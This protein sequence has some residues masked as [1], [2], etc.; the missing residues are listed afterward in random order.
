MPELGLGTWQNRGSQCIESVEKA[1]EIGYRHVDTAQIYGN[2]SEVG[3]GIKN[4]NLSREEI[5]LASKVWNDNLS[6]RKV[7]KSTEKSLEK[8]GVDRVDLMYIHWPRGSYQP[9]KTLK[10]FKELVEE[11]KIE[12]IGVSNFSPKQLDKA[13]EIAGEHIIA[14]QVEMHP[15]YQQEELLRKAREHGI[16]QVAYSP[17]ARGKVFDLEKVQEVAEKHEVSEAQVSLAW[18]MQKP[19][20]SAIPKASSEEHLKDNYNARELEMDKEDIEKI[21]SITREEKLVEI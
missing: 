4:S 21:E 19:N 14:N 9:E 1:L 15:L 2:E 13:M 5:F 20:V 10:A 6:P 12:N 11:G 7:K 8:L 3:K 16:E 18:L 17:L